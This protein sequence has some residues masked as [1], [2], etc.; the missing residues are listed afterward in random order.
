MLLLLLLFDWKGMGLADCIFFIWLSSLSPEYG[1][2]LAGSSAAS[3]ARKTGR[4]EDD[5]GLGRNSFAFAFIARNAI[6]LSVSI[7][8]TSSIAAAILVITPVCRAVLLSTLAGSLW[9][10]PWPW[11]FGGN[12]RI[13][14]QILLRCEGPWWL[15]LWL[16]WLFWLFWLW[17]FWLMLL[18]FGAWLLLDPVPIPVPVLT[19]VLL[20]ALLLTLVFTF[21]FAFAFS[22]LERFCVRNCDWDCDCDGVW[23]DASVL[24]VAFLWL[25]C[26]A[27]N[28]PLVVILPL[29]LSFA[30]TGAGVG[31]GA[32]V[33]VSLVRTDVE[34]EVEVCVVTG[35]ADC[36]AWTSDL[37]LWYSASPLI[38]PEETLPLLFALLP[39]LSPVFKFTALLEGMFLDAT[40]TFWIFF[41][42]AGTFWIFWDVTGTTGTF[43]EGAWALW[44]IPIFCPLPPL[45]SLPLPPPLPPPLPSSPRPALPRPPWGL[46]GP[47]RICPWPW[48]CPWPCPC[49]WTGPLGLSGL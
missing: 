39:C 41:C 7:L 12:L 16:F 3:Y 4:G 36:L 10:W 29:S 30:L 40:G 27:A 37:L 28:T 15:W 31:V 17:L 33:T 2:P 1:L 13:S 26:T 46:G 49:P 35:A 34:V 20:F 32:G 22:E 48:P 38:W 21:A 47:S 25:F 19:A 44:V 18:L 42:G 8:V 43:C 23:R 5:E 45:P 6:L 24:S 11:P 14:W 9:P